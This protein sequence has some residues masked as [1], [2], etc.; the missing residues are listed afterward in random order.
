[1]K[2]FLISNMYPSSDDPDYGVFVQN[3]EQALEKNGAEITEKAVISGRAKSFFEKL[4]NYRKFYAKI[5]SAYRKGNFDLIYLH[6]ISHSSPGLLL[7]K[8]LFGK[9]KKFVINVHGSDILIHHKG[10]L[11]RCNQRLLKNTDLLIVPSSYFKN[12]IAKKIPNFPQNKIY[13]SPSG[14][15]NSEIFYPQSKDNFKEVFHLGFVSRIEDDKGWKTFIEALKILNSTS[16]NLKVSLAGKG[17]KTLELNNLIKKYYLS[18][19]VKYIGVLSQKEL[20]DLYNHIDLL[21]FPT[22]SNESLG[23]VGLEAMAC[24]TPVV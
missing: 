19:R 17:S 24:G 20:N 12:I 22:H 13:I 1:M 21:I 2:I 6:F 15:I 14:G 10:F 23:L 16:L 9:K 5:I 11:K 7:A 4:N 3:I 18:E 8:I